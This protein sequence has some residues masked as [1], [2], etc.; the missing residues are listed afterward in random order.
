MMKI[1]L[2]SLSFSLLAVAEIPKREDYRRL[3]TL[4]EVTH[5]DEIAKRGW[6]QARP[7]HELW[8][9]SYWATYQ[10]GLAFQYRDSQWMKLNEKV[11]DF[12]AYF[13]LFHQTPRHQYV[14]KDLTPAEKYDLLIGSDQN[15]LTRSQWDFAQSVYE[16]NFGEIP[17]WRGL[18]DGFAA[19]ATQLPR[20]IN[21]VVVK[22]ARGEDLTILPEDIKAYA[23]LLY[24]EGVKKT[25]LLGRRCNGNPLS[26]VSGAC[27]AIHAASLHLALVN[28]IGQEKQTFI[29]DASK[30]KEVWNYPIHSYAFKYFHPFRPKTLLQNWHDA[31]EVYPGQEHRFGFHLSRSRETYWVIGVEATI[32]LQDMRDPTL[33]EVDSEKLDKLKE[34]KYRYTL[35][36]NQNGHIVDGD[37]I[38]DGPDFMWIVQGALAQSSVEAQQGIYRDPVSFKEPLPRELQLQAERAAAS[39]ETLQR[40]VTELIKK[41]RE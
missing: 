2:I 7:T 11:Y 15:T 19:A 9:G 32:Q 6:E 12:K 22:T 16:K 25:T 35:D 8:S 29:V 28:K 1:I 37:W 40:L 17:T 13:Q 36:V 20:P 41:S 24:A 21:P 26:W 38:N 31:K 27:K 5:L 4:P 14:T 34:V 33:A 3:L 10:G 30:G 18:C 39:G 23:T